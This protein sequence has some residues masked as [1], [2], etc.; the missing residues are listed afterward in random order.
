MTLESGGAIVTT[1]ALHQALRPYIVENFYV[2]KSAVIAFGRDSRDHNIYRLI[3]VPIINVYG[4]VI[5][6]VVVVG[7]IGM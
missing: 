4:D 6:M 1:C 3:G 2:G 5:M 7:L